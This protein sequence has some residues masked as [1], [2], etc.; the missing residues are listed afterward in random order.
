MDEPW[1]LSPVTVPCATLTVLPL[2][3]RLSALKACDEVSIKP[4]D[5][6]PDANISEL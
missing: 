6:L 2:S 3:F 4:I 1:L 5:M